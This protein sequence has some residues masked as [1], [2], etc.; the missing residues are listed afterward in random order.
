[1]SKQNIISTEAQLREAV[2]T[3]WAQDTVLNWRWKKWGP[4]PERRI[5]ALWELVLDQRRI[6]FAVEFKLNP[7]ARDVEFLAKQKHPYPLLLIAP[8]ISETLVRLCREKGLN[9]ADLNGKLWL[10]A[11][12]LLVEREVKNQRFRSSATLPDV[13]SVKSSRLARTLLCHRGR[14]WSH[15]ELVERTGLS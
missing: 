13:F 4:D 2:R 6:T 14:E 10:R 11:K 9:C 12:G 8:N 15:K 7:A 1:M 3:L 5:D